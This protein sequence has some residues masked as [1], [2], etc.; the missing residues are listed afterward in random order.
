MNLNPIEL[1][2]L[3]KRLI[4][5]RLT[6]YGQIDDRIKDGNLALRSGHDINYIGLSGLLSQFTNEK[7]G[8]QPVFPINI[9]G[10]REEK[11]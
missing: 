4:I 10:K 6:G 1:V 9:L 7:S 5:A 2:E 8:N 11:D 3:N